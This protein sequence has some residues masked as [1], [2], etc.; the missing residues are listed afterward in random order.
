MLGTKK[1]VQQNYG[2]GT[3]FYSLQNEKG[4]WKLEYGSSN[5]TEIVEQIEKEIEVSLNIENEMKSGIHN[6]VIKNQ[7]EVLKNLTQHV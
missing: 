7:R 5:L 6:E 3:S 2:D 1:L 4:S